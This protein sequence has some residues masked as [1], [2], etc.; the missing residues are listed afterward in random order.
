MYDNESNVPD[1]ALSGLDILRKGEAPRLDLL[2]R[3]GSGRDSVVISYFTSIRPRAGSHIQDDDV[4][5]L[6]K[7]IARAEADGA[8]NIDVFLCT[9]GGHAVMPWNFHAMFRDYF[10][11][12]RLG[13]IAPF[14]TYSAGTCIALGADEILMGRSSV[15]GP[16]DIQTTRDDTGGW[17]SVNDFGGFMRLLQEFDVGKTLDNKKTLDWLTRNADPIALG[18]AFRVWKENR[19]IIMKALTS[20]RKPLSARENE[21]IADYFL[22]EIGMHGQG[23]RRREALEAGLSF[24]TMLESSSCA[25]D[26]PVLFEQYAQ[27]M[28]LFSPMALTSS[29]AGR[30][31]QFGDENHVDVYGVHAAHTP[32]AIVESRYETNAAFFAYGS[33]RHWDAPPPLPGHTAGNDLPNEVYLQGG[34]AAQ[35]PSAPVL[36]SCDMHAP[37]PRPTQRPSAARGRRP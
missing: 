13:V 22:Y 14:E 36:W 19:R 37:A 11:K 21:K 25:D 28:K 34:K 2:E 17:M 26:V 29:Q 3:I 31:R 4:R 6:E 23:I 12:A 9:H 15:L 10:P 18:N 32:V 8:E 5:I 1:A 7:H 16:V 20:R 24:V 27:A 33:D 30:I 35:A